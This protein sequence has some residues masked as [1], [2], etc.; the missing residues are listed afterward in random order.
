M[1]AIWEM[2]LLVNER[3]GLAATCSSR[4]GIAEDM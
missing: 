3:S 4:F 1:S 2:P